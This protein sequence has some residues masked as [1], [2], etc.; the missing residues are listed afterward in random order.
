M[1]RGKLLLSFFLLP[2]GLKLFLFPSYPL[3]P[4]PPPS[5]C[6]TYC[7]RSRGRT[8]RE[9]SGGGGGGGGGGG[10]AEKGPRWMKIPPRL[11]DQKF[12]YPPT[13]TTT[14][15]VLLS[16]PSLI[17][18]SGIRRPLSS[19]RGEGNNLGRGKKKKCSL[20]LSSPFYSG[21]FRNA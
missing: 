16:L 19:G 3:P 11:T 13:T 21:S 4:I 18:F 10:C 17:S 8:E 9:I 14:E 12:F 20:L 5:L 15:F 7:W 1:G 2:L 6:A